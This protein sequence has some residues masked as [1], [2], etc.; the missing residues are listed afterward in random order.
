[1]SIKVAPPAPTEPPIFF[2]YTDRIPP[3]LKYT[4]SCVIKCAQQ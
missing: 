1:M 2:F 3:L 4:M